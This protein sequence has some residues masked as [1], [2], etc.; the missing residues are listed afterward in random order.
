MRWKHTNSPRP[1]KIHSSAVS[2]KGDVA[3]FFDIQG[4]LLLECIQFSGVIILLENRRPH[5]A[6]MCVEA[7]T[8]KKWEVLEHPA[9]SPNLSPCDYHIF[10]LL[11][12]SLM[13][14]RF[15]SN[16]KATVLNWFHDQLT[17]FSSRT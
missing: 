3:A 11:K 15:H 2:R 9:Y 8:R 7:L 6:K 17:S 13:G 12:E 5:V 4:S 1:K 14:Q 10:G 16:V